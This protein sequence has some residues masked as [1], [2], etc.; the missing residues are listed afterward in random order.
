MIR[1]AFFS[2]AA[3]AMTLGMFGGTTAI[4]TAQTGAP[5]HQVA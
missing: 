3:L 5:V 2:I 4:L 1:N